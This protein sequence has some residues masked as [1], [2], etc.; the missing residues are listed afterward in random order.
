MDGIK[1]LC[2]LLE[3]FADLTDILQSDGVSSSMAIMGMINAIEGIFRSKNP[4]LD[5][6]IF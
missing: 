1:I 5:Y 6:N 4:G 3:P 2:A